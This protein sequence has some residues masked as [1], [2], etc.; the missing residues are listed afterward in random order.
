MAR[1]ILTLPG[2][3]LRTATALAAIAIFMLAGCG[4]SENG[5][6]DRGRQLFVS[7]CGSCHT[8]TQAGTQGKQ[9]PNLDAAFSQAR[10]SGM[11]PDTIAGVVK[12]QVDNPRPTT[13]NPSTSMPPHLVEGDDLSDVAAYVSKVAGVPGIKPPPLGAPPQMFASNCASC[14]TLKA[15]NAGGTVGPDLDKALPGMSA[16]EIKQSIIDPA[17]KITPGYPSGVMPET[18][19]QLFPPAKLQA[20]VKYLQDNAGK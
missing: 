13:S 4:V 7:K 10:A 20:L 11:D 16:A 17:A 14:H 5:D 15:A 2:P 9:G 12:A 19:G 8:L 1:R 3:G 6:T 18:F